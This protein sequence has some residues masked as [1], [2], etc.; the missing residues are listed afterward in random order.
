MFQKDKID[1]VRIKVCANLAKPSSTINIIFNQ[2]KLNIIEFCDRFNKLTLF[3]KNS[4][5]L[6]VKV[7]I[8]KNK[9]YEILICSPSI[10]CLIK[11]LL[12]LKTFSQE[13]SKQNVELI[14]RSEVFILI[15]R[16][17]YDLNT[18]SIKQSISLIIGS[19]RSLGIGIIKDL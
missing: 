7:L 1:F 16:K 19:L 6:C 14:K 11:K 15:K 2:K 9:K 17:R 5:P 12:S 10:S 8:Y 4:E 3:N 18:F 13:P